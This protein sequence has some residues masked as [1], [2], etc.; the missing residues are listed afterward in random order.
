[1]VSHAPRA[2]RPEHAASFAPFERLATLNAPAS[3]AMTGAMHSYM[4]GLAACNEQ[5]SK[6]LTHRMQCDLDFARSLAQ[7]KDWQEAGALQMGWARG[8]MED[9]LGQA[10][11]MMRLASQTAAQ[12]L[13]PQPRQG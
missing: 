12:S 2:T 13:N 10:N 4:A 7:C 8:A 6:F 11:T 9:Y 5:V 3:A 1:M